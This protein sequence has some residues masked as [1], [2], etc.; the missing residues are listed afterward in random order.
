MGKLTYTKKIG[1]IFIFEVDNFLSFGLSEL[2]NQLEMTWVRVKSIESI[3]MMLNMDYHAI[4]LPLTS[5]LKSHEQRELNKIIL[6]NSSVQVL[7]FFHD[8]N[9]SS[10]NFINYSAASFVSVTLPLDFYEDVIYAISNGYRI[11][12][13]RFKI[14][15]GNEDKVIKLSAREE[16]VLNM[17]KDGESVDSM[18]K[19]LNISERTIRTYKRRFLIKL[20]AKTTRD[21]VKPC[22]C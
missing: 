16:A 18:S 22:Q 11:I 17:I 19:K 12:D 14:V 15:L 20:G 13:E 6:D 3:N 10:F 2:L 21:L 1:I 5:K 4:L 8:E 7:F 9:K